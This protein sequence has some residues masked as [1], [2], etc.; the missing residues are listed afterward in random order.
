MDKQDK[1]KQG[2]YERGQG[3]PGQ[4]QNPNKDRG[5]P[6]THSQN[7]MKKDPNQKNPGFDSTKKPFDNTK[8][9][10]QPWDKS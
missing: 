10:K 8:K 1:N 6:P 3:K 2:G 4:P 5:V 7:P 9:E